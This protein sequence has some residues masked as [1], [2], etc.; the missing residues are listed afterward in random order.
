MKAD[1]PLIG[2]PIDKGNRLITTEL[3]ADAA[4]RYLKSQEEFENWRKII[5][6]RHSC[7]VK[8][9]ATVNVRVPPRYK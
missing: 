1:I 7:G 4:K 8:S 3:W 2:L 6:L 5:E 9:E